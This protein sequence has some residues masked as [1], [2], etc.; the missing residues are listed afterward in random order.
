M[1]FRQASTKATEMEQVIAALE[2][3]NIALGKLQAGLIGA[4]QADALEAHQL[5]YWP[6][7]RMA[8]KAESMARTVRRFAAP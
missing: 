8:E 6:I 2:R 5:Y 3:L 1:M 7:I 4:E